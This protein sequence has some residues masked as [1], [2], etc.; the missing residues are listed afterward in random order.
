M[1]DHPPHLRQV[2][3]AAT[4]SDRIRRLQAEARNIAADQVSALIG[5]LQ[6]TARLADEIASGGEAYAVGVRDLARR[7]ADT[8]GGSALMLLAVRA[9]G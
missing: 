6:D 5:Q 1:T 8:L 2:P 9:R 3:A 7:L 4:P